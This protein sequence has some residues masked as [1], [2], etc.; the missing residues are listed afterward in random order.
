MWRLILEKFDIGLDDVEDEEQYE[1]LSEKRK[2][3]LMKSL[4]KKYKSYRGRLKSNYYDTEDTDVERLKDENKPPCVNKKEWK[5][6][7]EYFGSPKFQEMSKRNSKNRSCQ[8]AGH[9]AGTKS[10]AQ[11][12]HEVCEKEQ[13]M[14]NILEAYEITHTKIDKTPVN[15]VAKQNISKMKE[16][17]EQRAAG[18]NN[19]T[20]EEIYE[21]VKPKGKCQRDRR[22]GVSPSITSMYGSFSEGEQLRKEAEEAKKEANEAKKE[23]FEANEKN[24]VLTKEVKRFKSEMKNMKGCMEKFL[25]IMGYDISDLITNEVDE[26]SDEVS[27]DGED[28]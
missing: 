19:L 8:T 20:D 4:K 16:L 13:V 21:K 23:A 15:D 28:Q 17:L 22:M 27:S 12:I 18:K 6:L 25:N 7:V 3:T 10:F 1:K 26:E 24:K 14:P 5:W 2:K 11:V 9:T